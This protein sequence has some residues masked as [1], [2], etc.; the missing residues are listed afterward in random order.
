MQID[1]VIGN[2][3]APMGGA[4]LSCHFRAS[5]NAVGVASALSGKCH[6]VV[7]IGSDQQLIV[8]DVRSHQIVRSYRVENA[9]P[10]ACCFNHDASLLLVGYGDDIDDLDEV[11]RECTGPGRVPSFSDNEL[12]DNGTKKVRSRLSTYPST[13]LIAREK[14]KR[15]ELG[16]AQRHRVAS[17]KCGGFCILK[18][19]DAKATSNGNTSGDFV[20]VF[21]ARDSRHP[22]TDV[23]F[24]MDGSVFA[25]AS[26]DANIYIYNTG[27]FSAKVIYN[28][29]EKP[30]LNGF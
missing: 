4:L 17:S 1:A 24:S 20:V 30:V 11:T 28:L 16:P 23:K 18:A 21:E 6:E 26:R 9:I 2:S 14:K 3:L 8:W 27:D 22:I 15:E 19:V 12:K 10:S 5:I 29:L 7:S 13:A 25:V